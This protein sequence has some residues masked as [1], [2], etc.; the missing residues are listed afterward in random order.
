AHDAGWEFMGHGYT[1]MPTHLVEDQADMIAKTVDA[2]Q[3]FTVR[4]PAG[5]LGPGLTQTLETVDL[6][7]AAGVRYIGDWVLD[8]EP[9]RLSTATG[10]MVA[11]PYSVELNDVPTMAVRH[12]R[13]QEFMNR[14]CDTFD[15]LYMEGEERI[16]IMGIAVHPFL[17]GV[18]HR[19]KYLEN[20]LRYIH[21]HKDVCFM[22]GEQILAWYNE[23]QPVAEPTGI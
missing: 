4:S 6:L 16:R 11:M 18:P 21:G 15:R 8:D 2:I 17:S 23:V 7:H 1:Q 10:P 13:S 14:I 5:W 19:I 22:T 9:C 12:H 3:R 20:A